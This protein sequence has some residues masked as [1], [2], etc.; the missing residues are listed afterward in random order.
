MNDPSRADFRIPTRA[1]ADEDQPRYRC[2]ICQ[3]APWV[4]VLNDRGLDLARSWGDSFPSNW[5][6]ILNERQFHA[7]L[8]CSCWNSAK[9]V[10]RRGRLLEGTFDRDKHC[11]WLPY[12]EAHLR[13][14]LD[15]HL[16]GDVQQE[17]F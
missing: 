5:T 17:A 3:D 16:P 6:T 15:H 1:I 9:A 7:A 8:R 2:S 10:A 14:W 11:E 12:N 13:T 4:I